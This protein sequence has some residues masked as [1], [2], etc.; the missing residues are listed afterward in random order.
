[1]PEETIVV[2]TAVTGAFVVFMAVLM[3][4]DLNWRPDRSGG[5]KK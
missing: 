4:A 2:V 5:D 3:W 1:M